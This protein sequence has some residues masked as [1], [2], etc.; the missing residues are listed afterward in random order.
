GE[1]RFAKS[2]TTEM[3]L[4]LRELYKLGFRNFL[5]SNVMPF[6]CLP[7]SLQTGSV[8]LNTTMDLVYIH[9]KYL[10][11]AISELRKL[12][13]ANFLILD[14]FSAISLIIS[15]P[16]AQGIH[17]INGSCCNSQRSP[18][19]IVGCAVYDDRGKPL[20]HVCK[21]PERALFF[22]WYHLTQKGWE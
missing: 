17:M 3:E 7:A 18:F 19:N 16:T 21:H 4:Q 13:D 22:D 5:V 6:D 2:L 10:S 20:Y 11:Q 15:N 1:K 9:N 8:C 12:E 14:L